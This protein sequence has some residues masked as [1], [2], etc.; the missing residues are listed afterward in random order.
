MWSHVDQ[1]PVIDECRRIWKYFIL[2]G[3]T[4]D[5]KHLHYVL[6]ENSQAGKEDEW[7]YTHQTLYIPKKKNEKEK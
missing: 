2:D 5:Q 6:F 1:Q 4:L 7:E 3:N